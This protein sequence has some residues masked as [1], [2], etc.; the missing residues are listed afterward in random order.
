MKVVLCTGYG[1]PE[2][3]KI[4]DAPKPVPKAEEILVRIQSTAVNS[5]DVRTRKLDVEGLLKIAM[6]LVLG[7]NRPRNPILGTVYA[8]VVEQRGESVKYFR[9]GDLVF[10][11]SPGFNLDAVQNTS[12]LKSPLP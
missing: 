8:G 10:G 1:S 2:V 3:L 7:W 12:P 6:R 9:N 11:C 5:G 4:S